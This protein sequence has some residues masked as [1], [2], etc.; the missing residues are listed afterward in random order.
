MCTFYFESKETEN[1]TRYT[2]E[3]FVTYAIARYATCACIQIE[4]PRLIKNFKGQ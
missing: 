1:T 4:I 2:K 3:L